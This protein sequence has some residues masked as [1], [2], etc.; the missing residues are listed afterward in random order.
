MCYLPSWPTRLSRLRQYRS[1]HRREKDQQMHVPNSLIC[2]GKIPG[3]G[4][5]SLQ[6]RQ[7]GVDGCGGAVRVMVCGLTLAC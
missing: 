7:R 2:W 4:G 3:G 5:E 1:L 6:C